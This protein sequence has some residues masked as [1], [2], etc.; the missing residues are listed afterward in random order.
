MTP[1]KRA[2]RPLEPPEFLRTHFRP[3]RQQP[4]AA[5]ACGRPNPVRSTL[6]GL[7]RR[8]PLE[9]PDLAS[10]VTP[11]DQRAFDDEH[12]EPNPA[13]RPELTLLNEAL[14]PH[15]RAPALHWRVPT[16]QTAYA[17]DQTP[18]SLVSFLVVA[19]PHLVDKAIM[20]EP[21]LRVDYLELNGWVRVSDTRIFH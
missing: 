7:R 15:V 8:G 21:E 12:V 2:R 10:S 11:V 13:R 5:S 20:Q 6:I 19:L 16:D 1:S 14:S 17:S 4:T 3:I 9:A 18:F